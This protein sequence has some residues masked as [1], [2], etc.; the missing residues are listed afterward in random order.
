MKS[1]GSRGNAGAAAR[2]TIRL[3][4]LWRYVFERQKQ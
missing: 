1:M 3:A 2:L 4:C